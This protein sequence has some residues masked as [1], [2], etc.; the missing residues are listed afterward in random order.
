MANRIHTADLVISRSGAS[1]IAELIAARK[2][3]I[4][5][6]YPHAMDNHQYY[7]AL[8]LKNIGV[9]KLYEEK[10][11][12]YS[13]LAQFIDSAIKDPNILS[14]MQD[15]YKKALPGHPVEELIKVIEKL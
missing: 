2:P 4:F 8:E 14:K 15:S 7:N 11:L 1:T 9:A 12:V 6:P 10:S 5:L 3:A 13:E